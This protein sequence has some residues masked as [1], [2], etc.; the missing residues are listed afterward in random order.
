MEISIIVVLLF[1]GSPGF[2]LNLHIFEWTYTNI[3]YSIPD[4]FRWSLGYLINIGVSTIIYLIVIR[5]KNQHYVFLLFWAPGAYL[6]TSYALI[7]GAWSGFIPQNIITTFHY[8][9]LVIGFILALSVRPLLYNARK[10]PLWKL[11]IINFTTWPFFI[12]FR[13]LYNADYNLTNLDPSLIA[14]FLVVALLLSLLEKPLFPIFQKILQIRTIDIKW[15]TII[16]SCSFTLLLVF[17][18]AIS[19]YEPYSEKIFISDVITIF[20]SM[21]ITIIGFIMIITR[22]DSLKL[23]F[24]REVV[25]RTKKKKIKEEKLEITKKKLDKEELIVEALPKEI[26]MEEESKEHIERV[27]ED[28]E[29]EEFKVQPIEEVE[30]VP[31]ENEIEEKSLGQDEVIPEKIEVIEDIIQEED[32]R[33]SIISEDLSIKEEEIKVGEVP[34]PLEIEE[35][36]EELVEDVLEISED[37]IKEETFVP[38]MEELTKDVEVKEVGIEKETI[39]EKIDEI[40]QDIIKEEELVIEKNEVI[41]ETEL[42]QEEIIEEIRV[43][44]TGN[45]ICQYCGYNNPDDAGFCIQCGQTLVKK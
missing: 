25:E 32:Q 7:S 26:Y 35:E 8:T 22:F 10:T 31:V 23:E 40:S 15:T 38:S 9:F 3:P 20:I 1:T 36:K 30:M 4:Q 44:P 12:I 18:F 43:L 39:I 33:E 24:K 27:P 42:V 34:K 6:Y 17:I 16:I 28:I 14:S 41:E 2:T 37:I 29:I 5:K 19:P 21:V 45:L 11:F 13:A